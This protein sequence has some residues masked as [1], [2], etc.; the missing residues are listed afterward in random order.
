MIKD[1]LP[2]SV[3]QKIMGLPI[4]AILPDSQKQHENL[5]VEQWR[6]RNCPVLPSDMIPYDNSP[7][8]SGDLAPIEEAP[9]SNIPI[10]DDFSKIPSILK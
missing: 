8:I 5:H 2:I 3:N 4:T 1:T 6:S 10:R 9:V 7:S